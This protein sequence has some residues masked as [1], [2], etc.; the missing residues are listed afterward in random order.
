[1][2]KDNPLAPNSIVF[3]ER[4]W[5]P[6]AVIFAVLIALTFFWAFY[7]LKHY[8]E[9]YDLHDYSINAQDGGMVGM[10]SIATGTPGPMQLQGLV[11]NAVVTVMDAAPQGRS[12]SSGAIVHAEGYILTTAHSIQGVRDLAVVVSSSNGPLKY[13]AKLIKLHK[14]HDL[15]LLKMV[16]N[17]KFRFLKLADTQ[18]TQPGARLTAFG[19]AL[20]G[21]I[22]AK[23]G[24][25]VQRGLSIN[26]DKVQLTH[27][28]ESDVAFLPQ[29]SGGPMINQ[30]A[31]LVGINIVILQ[32]NSNAVTGYT[33]P[34]HVIRSHF[35]DVVTFTPALTDPTA[36]TAGKARGIAAAWW[37]SAHRQFQPGT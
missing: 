28:I 18:L 35:Q 13:E 15:A 30:Q 22:I 12:L 23:S 9:T 3:C 16:T 32:P 26:V 21:A 24:P 36:T 2:H 31:E 34:A 19:K 1:M 7:V 29:H 5:K 37:G 6:V 10:V 11:G 4:R 27:L 33:V 17:D 14:Q 8:L 25:M 20:N